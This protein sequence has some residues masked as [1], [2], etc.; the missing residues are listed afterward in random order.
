V[1]SLP[2]QGPTAA[3]AQKTVEPLLLDLVHMKEPVR[4]PPVEGAVLDVLADD[5]VPLLI[6]PAEKAA[7]SV[8]VRRRVIV[9]FVI[10]PMWHDNSFYRVVR[11]SR[12]RS[13]EAPQ[14]EELS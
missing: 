14:E 6:A 1:A 13:R 5:P 4:R 8:I 11:P 3:R 9:T 12:P 7:A 10:M 2:N